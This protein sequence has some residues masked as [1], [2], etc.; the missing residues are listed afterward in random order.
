MPRLLISGELHDVVLAF[1]RL[2][3]LR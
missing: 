3:K 1:I 2:E